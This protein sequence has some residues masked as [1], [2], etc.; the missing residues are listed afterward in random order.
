[1]SSPPRVSIC[2]P[3][4][5]RA[6][7]IRQTLETVLRQT[8]ADF[9][10]IVSDDNSSDETHEVVCSFNDSR[11]RY[12]RN[13]S[14]LRMPENLN[15]A[16]RRAVGEHIVVFHDHDLYEPTLIEE[17]VGVLDRNPG[18]GFVHTGL[19]WVNTETGK[20]T[21]IVGPWS[22]QTRGMQIF[23][24]LLRRWDCPIC[25][26]TMVRRTCYDAIGLY[27]PQFGFISD[28]DMW[29]RLSMKYD[30]GYVATP[31]ITCL[32]REKDHEFA[33]FNW[34]IPWN[35]VL[36]HEINLKRYC[37][38]YLPSSQYYKYRF[39][40]KKELFLIKIM[41]YL[42]YKRDAENI[43]QGIQVLQDKCNFLTYTSFTIMYWL[44]AKV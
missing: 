19:F 3:T 42:F 13:A 36:I 34:H 35:N 31:L 12:Y 7:F 26:L 18:V 14:N 32:E 21:R 17:M 22:E 15:G 16:I 20:K 41:L 40:I 2:M 24:E 8:Y 37:S 9:E 39:P 29:M 6:A 30:V 33:K 27:D 43:F 11:I 4:Y 23:K 38:Q 28:V 5:N 10:L 25:A 44:N 1:M